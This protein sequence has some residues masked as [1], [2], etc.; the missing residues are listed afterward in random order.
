MSYSQ[1]Y[2]ATISGTV[3]ETVSYPASEHGSSHTVTLHWSENVGVSIH[4]DT[5]SF[6]HSVTTLKHHIDGLTGA[7][8]ATEAAQIEEKVRGADAIGKSVTTGFFQLIG[9]E[10]SQ[11]MVALK[12][13]VDSLFL[14]LNDMKSA[15]QRI[16][17]NMQQ[18]Y[19]RITDR[20]SATFEE[21][22]RELAMRIAS[23]DDAVHALKREISLESR[24]E[25]DSTLST[26]P[27]IFGGE[28]SRAQSTLLAGALRSRMNDLLQCAMAY[29]ATE[30]RTSNAVSTMLDAAGRDSGITVSLPV[31]YLAANPSPGTPV[32]QIV[33][34]DAPGPLT[35][36]AEMKRR[37]L[38]HFRERN[39]AWKPLPSESKVQIERFLFPLIDAVHTASREQDARVRQRILH[40]WNAHTPE[41]LPL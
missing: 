28:N 20:Y 11:Q 36:D 14:K 30:K 5:S 13:K 17:Q 40:L 34:S 24:R 6:D 23:L 21:L 4:V 33:L 16:Q 29:L 18:D 25:F 9:S 8:V 38:A 32:E 19:H 39:L 41:A 10:I 31:A 27:T 15:C 26:V 37:I 22:D 7:V 35:N 12:S 3:S 1:N 2:N